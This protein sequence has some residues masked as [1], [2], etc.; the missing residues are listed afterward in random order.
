MNWKIQPDA[1]EIFEFYDLLEAILLRVELN[2][3]KIT[4]AGEIEWSFGGR[5]IWVNI[6][7]KQEV[8]ILDTYVK[9]V[10][11]QGYEYKLGFD[12]KEINEA[13]TPEKKWWQ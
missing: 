7:G 5:D 2:T 9:L 6:D 11:F 1:A 3:H 13:E 12:G 8:E 10:D 4:N